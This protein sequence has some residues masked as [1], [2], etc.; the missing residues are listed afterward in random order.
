[1]NVF[2]EVSTYICDLPLFSKLRLTPF[3]K[4]MRDARDYF[5]VGTVVHDEA[6]VAVSVCCLPAM[7][8]RFE[9]KRAGDGTPQRNYVIS[10]GSGTLEDYWPFIEQILTGMLVVESVER[11]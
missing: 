4:H 6:T 8:W 9:I 1:M 3:H 7:F 5:D 11:A 10:T 2:N